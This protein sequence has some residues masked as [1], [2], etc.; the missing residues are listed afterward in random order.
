MTRRLKL[1]WPRIYGLKSNFG[2][3]N[4]DSYAF[5]HCRCIYEFIFY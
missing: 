5:G 3:L 4:F 1:L 2:G